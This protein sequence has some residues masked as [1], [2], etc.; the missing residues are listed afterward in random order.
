M[1][2]KKNKKKKKTHSFVRGITFLFTLQQSDSGLNKNV[3]ATV[4]TFVSLDVGNCN[5]HKNNMRQTC[6]N[7]TADNIPVEL[8]VYSGNALYEA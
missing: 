6:Y 1:K 3:V 8:L 5:S 7:K 2:E 4:T